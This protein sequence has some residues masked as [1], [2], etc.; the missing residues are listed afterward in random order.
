MFNFLSRDHAYTWISALFVVLVVSSGFFIN[1]E[2]SPSTSNTALTPRSEL[3][4]SVRDSTHNQIQDRRA[5]TPSSNQSS[6]A[7]RE[8]Y[9]CGPGRPCANGACC[10]TSGFCGYGPASCGTG[11]ISNCNAHAECGEFSSPANKKCPLNTCCSKHGFCGTT[12]VSKEC[13]F[14]LLQCQSLCMCMY[15]CILLDLELSG[16]SAM[17][18]SIN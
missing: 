6:L 2:I 10:G 17:A 11:C 8:D 9:S 12:K 15:E 14:A 5:E 3:S 1:F 16:L 18:M 13:A 4:V 7:R